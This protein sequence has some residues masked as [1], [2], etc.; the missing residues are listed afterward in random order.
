M[1]IYEIEVTGNFVEILDENS[2]HIEL[3]GCIRLVHLS[4]TKFKTI[5]ELQT[6]IE[7]LIFPSKK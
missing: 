2:A 1:T 3:G 6:A 7:A 4:D 5:A